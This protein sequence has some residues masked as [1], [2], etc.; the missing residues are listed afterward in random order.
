MDTPS[1]I[2]IALGAFAVLFALV[3]SMALLNLLVLEPG[4]TGPSQG[5]GPQ[6]PNQPSE[7]FQPSPQQPGDEP[8][9]TEED[10]PE[11][12]QSPCG[13][14]RD[15]SQASAIATTILALLLWILAVWWRQARQTRV[16]NGWAIAALVFT[17]LAITLWFAHNIIDK[18][19]SL[20][21][22]DLDTCREIAR[23]LLAS[24][25]AFLIPTIGFLAFA[26]VRKRAGHPFLGLWSGAGFVFLYLTIMAFTGWMVASD[27]CDKFFEP[28]EV[29]ID[30]DE[31]SDPGQD[32][33]NN[34]NGG[35]PSP[36]SGGNDPPSGGSQPPG[37]GNQGSPGGSNAPDLVGV[38]QIS[39]VALLV[40]MG[41]AAVVVIIVLAVRGGP[42][43][44][45]MGGGAAQ[46]VMVVEDRGSLLAML[47]RKDLKSDDKVVAAYRAFLAWCSVRG[48]EKGLHETPHEHARRAVADLDL[49][50]NEVF[51][52]AAAYSQTRLGDEAPPLGLRRQAI[53]F[54]RRMRRREP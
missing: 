17:L 21:V 23:N 20:R 43:S 13:P 45:A 7:P 8:N 47:G 33:G 19:C 54:S 42:K 32:P 22:T 53:D 24:F 10:E 38:P 36:P 11:K 35:D 39:P 1:R 34:G 26:I 12:K 6:Q 41:I 29:E 30:P 40:I 18:I 2:R 37:S 48:V 9:G 49:P 46:E 16:M 5:F 14:A 27:I 51:G 4:D 15:I 44:F 50:E 52:L 31:P 3:S 25:I 28:P